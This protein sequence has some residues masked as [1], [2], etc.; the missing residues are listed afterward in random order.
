MKKLILILAL[1]SAAGTAMAV[2]TDAPCGDNVKCWR[3][4]AQL[5]RTQAQ[6]AAGL[7]W[8]KVEL[9][10]RQQST[11]A[12]ASEPCTDADIACW[13]RL[14]NTARAAD[15]AMSALDKLDART[16]E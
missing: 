12:G 1:A 6:N 4:Y 7:Y 13:R 9:R 10:A 5:A 2:N 11:R 8:K 16:G 3:E 14:A 15:K